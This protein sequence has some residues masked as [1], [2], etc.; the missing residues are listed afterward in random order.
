[1]TTELVTQIVILATAIVGLYKAA[2]IH[3]KIKESE[4]LQGVSRSDAGR[5]FDAVLSYAGVLLFMLGMPAF[6]WAFTSIT[7]NIGTPHKPDKSPLSIPFVMSS[8]PTPA[9]I[10]L[11]AAAGIT[12]SSDQRDALKKVV[13]YA[14]NSCDARVAIVAA[15]A[16]TYSSD[17]RDSLMMIVD[18]VASPGYQKRCLQKNVPTTLVPGY[19]LKGAAADSSA[20]TASLPRPRGD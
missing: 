5:V 17:Q 10:M 14:L 9:E 8:N 4:Q 13:V 11:A 16:I 1:M 12:Y 20:T 19:S 15:E 7:N 3:P 18:E 2:T 6:I